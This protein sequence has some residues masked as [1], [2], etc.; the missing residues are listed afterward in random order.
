MLSATKKLMMRSVWVD[1]GKAAIFPQVSSRL[2]S[3]YDAV[4]VG[5]GIV[6]CTTALLL[7]NAGKSVCLLEGGLVCSGTSGFNTA[8]L[9]A[10]QG[11]AYSKITEMHSAEKAKLYYKMN[12]EAIDAVEGIARKHNIDCDFARAS[13]T[14]WTNLP[15]NGGF[16]EQEFDLS[17]RMGID[18][19]LL[20]KL[21]LAS[22]LPASIGAIRG[23]RFYNQAHFNPY[24][25][26]MGVSK[27]VDGDGSAV[28]ENSRVT[29]VSNEEGIHDIRVNNVRLTAGAVV[30]ATQLPILDR[31]LHFAIFP[32]KRSLCVAIKVSE[33]TTKL[34]NMYINIEEPTRSFN[35]ISDD[36]III[37]GQG[38]ANGDLIDTEAE[39]NKLENWAR[40]NFIVLEVGNR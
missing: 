13:H 30:L 38:F 21:D 37:C 32:P 28:F 16:I 11:L 8:K 17:R 18:C 33:S 20:D 19:D 4:V 31:S 23:V 12:A 10:Q 3:H 29:N 34:K 26:C 35:P 39:Y 7:K 15:L 36:V 25:F 9:S 40:E 27:L 6:G 14:S 2:K 24:K 5:A 22:E 1:P